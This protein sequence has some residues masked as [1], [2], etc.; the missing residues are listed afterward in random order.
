MKDK[1]KDQLKS[2]V[3]KF[4]M[5]LPC[6]IEDYVTGYD[7]PLA[8]KYVNTIKTLIND[9]GI[10]NDILFLD[11]K[12]DGVPTINIE[13]ALPKR[14]QIVFERLIKEKHNALRDIILNINDNDG[15]FTSNDIK[16]WLDEDGKYYIYT[17][18]IQLRYMLEYLTEVILEEDN[19]NG[20]YYGSIEKYLD[21][22][23]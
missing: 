4:K 16:D 21:I 9:I 15:E 19:V 1:E 7:I 6:V 8:K 18:P 5:Q 10:K 22:N 23:L 17:N 20:K 11:I 2:N 12:N 3:T 13:F 14:S